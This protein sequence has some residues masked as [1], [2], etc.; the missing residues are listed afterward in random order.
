[1]TVRHIMARGP[2]CVSEARRGISLV[3][4]HMTR[5]TYSDPHIQRRGRTG[6]VICQ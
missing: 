4:G 2:M 1:M 5:G 3:R 6:E